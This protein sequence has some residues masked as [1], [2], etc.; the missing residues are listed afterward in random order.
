MQRAFYLRDEQRKPVALV[1]VEPIDDEQPGAIHFA[2]S[3]WHSDD[4]YDRTMG[5]HIASR[6]LELGKSVA[7][8]MAPHIKYK[9]IEHIA[10]MD[11]PAKANRY[12]PGNEVHIHEDQWKYP[13]RTRAA[14]QL[15]LDANQP[16]A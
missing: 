1:L 4:V 3:T 8:R 5:Y 9:I 2:V 12:H 11:D 10:K 16:A 14:A 13:R 7:M 6:R 15:W